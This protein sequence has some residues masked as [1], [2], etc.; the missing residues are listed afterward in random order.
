M[1]YPIYLERIAFGRYASKATG[2]TMAGG[3]YS[4]PTKSGGYNIGG[5]HNYRIINRYVFILLSIRYWLLRNVFKKAYK[6]LVD[7]SWNKQHLFK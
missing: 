3:H 7:K 4:F 2:E 1:I 6:K 5:K